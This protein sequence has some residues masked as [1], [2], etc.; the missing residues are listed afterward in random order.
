M[1][2]VEYHI[3]RK[4]ATALYEGSNARHSFEAQNW[5]GG[6]QR[7]MD[8]GVNVDENLSKGVDKRCE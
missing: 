3:G 7:T 2:N 6:L 4:Q 5:N 1:T 8:T